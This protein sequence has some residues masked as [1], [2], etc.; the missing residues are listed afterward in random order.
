VR[1]AK[2]MLSPKAE[3]SLKAANA[4]SILYILGEYNKSKVLFGSIQ[5][6]SPGN[7]FRR[8]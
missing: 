7:Y 3:K 4:N 1:L 2:D 6:G 8:V 5:K